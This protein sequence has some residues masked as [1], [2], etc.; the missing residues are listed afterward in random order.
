MMKL[1]FFNY[2]TLNGQILLTNDFGKYVFVTPEQ[3][4]DLVYGTIDPHSPLAK[5]LNDA[6]MAYDASNLE[7]SFLMANRLRAYKGFL[8]NATALHIFVVTTVCNMNCVYCQANNGIHQSN[9]F[10]SED[11]AKKAVDIALSSPARH[12]SFEFQGGEPLLNFKIIRSIVE[13]AEEHNENHEIEYNI[14][15][16]LTLITDEILAFLEKY[17]VN[18]ATSIDGNRELHDKNRPFLNNSGSY[19]K[20][21]DSVRFIQSHGIKVGAIQTTT[22][23]SFAH[24][25][26]ILKTYVD[27]GFDSIFVRPLTPLGKALKNWGEIGYTASEFARF[28]SELLDNVI[29][30]NK[31][32][33]YLREEHAAILM[34]K[35][36]GRSVNYMELRSPCGAGI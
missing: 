12:L 3:F 33:C 1:N 36:S 2:K 26:E 24:G 28:Y 32:G 10:M 7:S 9:V 31:R 16:N 30:I 27:L 6:Y 23:A 18:I 14:V 4:Y 11:T 34:K 17:S 20:V 29:T 15:S 21:R 22:R 5:K 25:K 35:I 19:S 8:T 13:Y